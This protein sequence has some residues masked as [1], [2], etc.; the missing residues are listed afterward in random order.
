M[1][2]AY[3]SLPLGTPTMLGGCQYSCET[4]GVS[5]KQNHPSVHQELMHGKFVVQRGDKKF[6]IMAL[7][8]SHEHSI[9]FLKEDIG[10]KGLCG[11]QEET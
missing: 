3:G 5:L 11:Q 6:S 9:T 10:A 2:C 8:Q 7:Y 1:N 4:W